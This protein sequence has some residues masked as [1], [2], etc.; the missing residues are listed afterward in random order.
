MSK[1]TTFFA[2][3]EE[4]SS[5]P[6]TKPKPLPKPQG[7]E[8]LREKEREVFAMPVLADVYS[9][10][11]GGRGSASNASKNA[12]SSFL[13]SYSCCQSSMCSAQ[14]LP[15]SFQRKYPGNDK[16]RES[17]TNEKMFRGWSHKEVWLAYRLSKYFSVLGLDF[18]FLSQS[19]SSFCKSQL[20]VCFESIL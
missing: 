13:Y 11:V 20:F 18:G 6:T 14:D 10:G 5:T 3:G 16:M 7:E 8:R 12:C 19:S 17:F 1:K 2:V 15:P 4:T 9:V